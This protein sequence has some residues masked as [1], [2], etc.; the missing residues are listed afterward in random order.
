MLAAA[1]HAWAPQSAPRKQ[2]HEVVARVFA[3]ALDNVLLRNQRQK[4]AWRPADS[5]CGLAPATGGFSYCLV[6]L[7]KQFRPARA[8]ACLSY[9]SLPLL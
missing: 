2:I 5:A 3:T 9:F 4:R 7:L 8:K 6:L 1:I